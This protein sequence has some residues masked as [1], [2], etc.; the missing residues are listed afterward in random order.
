MLSS[1]PLQFVGSVFWSISIWGYLIRYHASDVTFG[2]FIQENLLTSI[3]QALCFLSFFILKNTRY[4]IGEIFGIVLL[5]FPIS[6]WIFDL[7][8]SPENFLTFVNNN[9]LF[10]I[11]ALGCVSGI[12]F[13]AFKWVMKD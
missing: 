5:A 9:G 8:N 6:L 1:Y 3:L 4:I 2:T 11:L 10:S 12:C 13:I 7:K